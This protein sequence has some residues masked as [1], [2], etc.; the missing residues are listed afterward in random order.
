MFCNEC[1]MELYDLEFKISIIKMFKKIKKG[2]FF[3]KKRVRNKNE[4]LR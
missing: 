4:C 1:F 3:F 2:K